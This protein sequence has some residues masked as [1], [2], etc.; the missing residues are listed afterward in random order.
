MSEEIGLKDFDKKT[1]ETNLTWGIYDPARSTL[2]QGA[3]SKAK[4][5]SEEE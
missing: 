1:I 2:S 5:G 3:G 4:E